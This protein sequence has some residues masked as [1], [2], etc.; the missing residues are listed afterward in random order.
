[1]LYWVHLGGTVSE[2]YH[3]NGYNNDIVS[4]NSFTVYTGNEEARKSFSSS[5]TGISTSS[6]LS[7]YMRGN[8]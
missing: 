6:Y 7:L 2:P 5:G 3:A 8:L 1:M 4:N